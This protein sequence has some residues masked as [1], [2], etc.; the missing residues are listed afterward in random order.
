MCATVSQAS[1]CECCAVCA[2][3]W[4]IRTSDGCGDQLHLQFI[5]E[6]LAGGCPCQAH[7]QLGRSC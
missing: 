3:P 2:A 6:M 7:W 5:M 4:E 1:V